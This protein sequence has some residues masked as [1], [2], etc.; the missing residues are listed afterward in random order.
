[1][2]NLVLAPHS[3]RSL[4][5]PFV[6]TALA[7][8]AG[9]CFN[10]ASFEGDMKSAPTAPNP[11]AL[12]DSSAV[13]PPAN[14]RQ[15]DAFRITLA[16]RKEVCVSGQTTD[17]AIRVQHAA[18]LLESFSSPKN[19]GKLASVKSK[20][21][22][23]IQD[24]ERSTSRGVVEAVTVFEACFDNKNVFTADTEYLTM[25]R[26]TQQVANPLFIAWHFTRT[27]E[28]AKTGER[29]AVNGSNLSA[30]DLHMVPAAD[31]PLRRG[32]DRGGPLAPP[33][34]QEPYTH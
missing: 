8:S 33:V 18:F 13:P 4:L 2:A 25:Q 30:P 32:D 16:D 15:G 20:R 24:T 28:E 26:E 29:H 31:F 34:W 14:S 21:V 27:V 17:S 11:F 23:I 12:G 10:M 9:G 7:V 3:Q 19:D 22:R 1:M 6:L 5:V